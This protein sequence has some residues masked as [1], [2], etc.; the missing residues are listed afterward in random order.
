MGPIDL[1]TYGFWN[2]QTSFFDF[3][4]PLGNENFSSKDCILK[5]IVNE[6]GDKSKVLHE[7][8][9]FITLNYKFS[10]ECERR[11]KRE[12]GNKDEWKE[13]SQKPTTPSEYYFH[14]SRAE[15][16]SF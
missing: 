16:C 11:K 4:L 12:T 6:K 2:F 5:A 9:S 15:F 10:Y 14:F 1:P 3:F 7:S 13:I 8:Y